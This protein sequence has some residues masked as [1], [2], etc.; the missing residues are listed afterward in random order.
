MSRLHITH[1]TCYTYNSP[2]TTS[3]NEARM[4]PVTDAQQ[5]TLESSIAIT[6]RQAVATTYRDYWGTRVTSFDVHV[7]HGTLEVLASATVEVHRIDP[8]LADDGLVDW[9][10][11]ES[12]ETVH[13]F[14]DFLPQ[15]RLSEPGADARERARTLRAPRPHETARNVLEWLDGAM[16]YQ[17]GVTAVTSGAEEALSTGKGVCQDLAH[18]GIGMMRALG[19][20]ARY[21][22]GYIHPKPSAELGTEVA[23]QSH[24][25]LE[26]WDGAWHTWDP[27]NSKPAGNLHVLVGRGRD[28]RDVTP[29]KGI[30]SGGQGSR[31]SVEVL[32]TQL[33]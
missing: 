28:Y 2:A 5:I 24:A 3:Y 1:R 19:I 33:A 25:W 6:P 31:L 10:R 18:I 23:G 27:T 22:S 16:S 30:V 11:M 26:W 32:M 17:P 21:V 29:L 14:S 12:M 20:P 15:T 9:D 4:T 8:R 13:E 7:P